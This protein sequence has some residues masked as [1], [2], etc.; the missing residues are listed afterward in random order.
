MKRW[1]GWTLLAVLCVSAAH[2]GVASG[3]SLSRPGRNPSASRNRYA[4]EYRLLVSPKWR[5]DFPHLGRSFRVLGPSTDPNKKTGYNCI[6]NSLNT[7]GRWVWPGDRVSDFDKLYRRHGY[8]RLRKPD[9]GH[10]PRLEKVV[11]Y[12]KKKNGRWVCTHAARQLADGSWTSKLGAGPLIKHPDADS[13][14]GPSYGR[15]IAVYVRVR[16]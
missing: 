16:G 6:A 4:A 1:I 12:A 2:V 3:A 11:L 13:V 7:R 9:Y 8:R 14:A 5:R 10:N 15:P